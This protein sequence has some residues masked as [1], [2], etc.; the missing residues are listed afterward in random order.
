MLHNRL[1][2]LLREEEVAGVHHALR[3]LHRLLRIPGSNCLSLLQLFNYVVLSSL[4]LEPAIIFFV[5]HA[6]DEVV[7][8]CSLGL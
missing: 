5:S 8:R 3:V 2:V 4:A 7:G 6:H 1:L